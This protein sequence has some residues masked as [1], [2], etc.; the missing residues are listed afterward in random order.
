[1]L[2]NT[3]R[4]GALGQTD[5]DITPDVRWVE[6][7]LFSNEIDPS[8]FECF[9]EFRCWCCKAMWYHSVCE[10]EPSACSP[11]AA[12]VVRHMEGWSRKLLSWKT[13]C[14]VHGLPLGLPPLVAQKQGEEVPSLARL[15]FNPHVSLTGSA[16][17][18]SLLFNHGPSG[19]DHAHGVAAGVVHLHGDGVGLVEAV[20]DDG[21]D[22]DLS[23]A[24]GGIGA[25]LGVI[26]Q[27]GSRWRWWC[28]R[29]AGGRIEQQLFRK[30]R[31][32]STERVG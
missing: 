24:G 12:V 18:S 10:F 9:G 25:G 26:E 15:D 21:L 8:W 20:A 27:R 30:K 31:L 3:Y 19:D 16:C 28:R 1:M 13:R 5:F 7:I 4:N 14:Q 6:I 23:G 11:F 2:G 32:S 22:L 29:C 17:W